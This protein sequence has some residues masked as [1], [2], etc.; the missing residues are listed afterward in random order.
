[1]C[2]TSASRFPSRG[3]DDS[4]G[5]HGGARGATRTYGYTLL[6]PVDATHLL[7]HHLAKSALEEG[8]ERARHLVAQ[9]IDRYLSMTQG[10]QK[11]GTNRFINQQTG[12]EELAPIDRNTSDA[13]RAKYGVPPLA[14][15]LK[16]FPEQK[17][18]AGSP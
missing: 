5:R 13:E 12:E 4:V 15:L 1:M 16:Q 14:E 11:Y 17:K 6:A 3:A 8:H 7:A 18:P 10:Y 9:T 2:W